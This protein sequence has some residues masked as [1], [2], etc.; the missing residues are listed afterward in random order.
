MFLFTCGRKWKEVMTHQTT[1]ADTLSDPAPPSLFGL[2]VL[3]SFMPVQ[4]GVACLQRLE[5][6]PPGEHSLPT[7]PG[8]RIGSKTP[9]G[10]FTSW[11]CILHISFSLSPAGM[12][13]AS[14][15]CELLC[16][17]TF[18]FFCIWPKTRALS[19]RS[20]TE[21]TVSGQ[22]RCGWPPLPTN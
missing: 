13:A 14:L 22:D 1:T 19:S 10:G 3:K 11:R 5:R 8:R 15:H 2:T 18:F 21:G 17:P 7:W 6:H 16:P 12:H 20:S 9:P 4:V